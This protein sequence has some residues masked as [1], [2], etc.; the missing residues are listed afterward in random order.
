MNLDGQVKMLTE[1]RLGS[2]N[3]HMWLDTAIW[4]T[5]EEIVGVKEFYHPDVH[6]LLY[7]INILENMLYLETNGAGAYVQFKKCLLDPNNPGG[8][9]YYSPEFQTGVYKEFETQKAAQFHP[10]ITPGNIGWKS[11][12]IERLM[13]HF[14]STDQVVKR[15]SEDDLVK[16]QLKY[17][18][19]GEK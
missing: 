18:L 8:L 5:G 17:K 1:L 12:Y 15:Y 16:E 11:K 4:Y 9:F 7:P 6:R 13:R 19:N 2:A 10:T 14:M 3:F